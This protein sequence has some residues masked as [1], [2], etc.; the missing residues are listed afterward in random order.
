MYKVYNNQKQITTGFSKFLK[1]VIPNIRKT[2]LNFIPSVM[3]GMIE[4][5]SCASSDIAKAL[6]DEA[7]WAQFD[8][9]VKRINRLWANKHFNGRLLFNEVIISILSNYK[10]KHKDKNVFYTYWYSRHSYIL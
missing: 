10:K 7:K 2:Q 6:K 9:I 5:E 3:F 4:S 1:K 8:S